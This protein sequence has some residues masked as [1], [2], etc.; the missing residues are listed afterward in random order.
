MSVRAEARPRQGHAAVGRVSMVLLTCGEEKSRMPVAKEVSQSTLTERL[1]DLIAGRLLGL[2]NQ[3]DRG[4]LS[5]FT[6]DTDEVSDRRDLGA[7]LENV[8][9]RPLRLL[10]GDRRTQA[11]I[12]CI[13][14]ESAPC[15]TEGRVFGLHE[16]D[17]WRGGGSCWSSL[18]SS[19]PAVGFYRGPCR[20]CGWST[21]V[22]LPGYEA[23]RR[24]ESRG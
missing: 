11:A 2:L 14:S 17:Q 15:P 3:S 9:C 19:D 12:V 24:G 23:G 6:N 16:S 18:R 4:A 22:H 13:W 1:N 8:T 21:P 10:A 20:S 7:A 5:R